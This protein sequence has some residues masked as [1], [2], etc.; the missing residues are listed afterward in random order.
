[1]SFLHEWQGLLVVFN[2]NVMAHLCGKFPFYAG[3]LTHLG[4]GILCI[5]PRLPIV[6]LHFLR[7]S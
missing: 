4:V 6:G 3:N 2:E 7:D 1:M 5:L